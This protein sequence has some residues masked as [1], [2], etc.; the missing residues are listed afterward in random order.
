MAVVG[1]HAPATPPWVAFGS[2]ATGPVGFSEPTLSS[3]GQ[4]AFNATLVGDGI[5]E[6]NDFGIWAGSP[7]NLQLVARAGDPAPG[8]NTT[9]AGKIYD[10]GPDSDP[11]PG[12]PSINSAGRVAFS[13]RLAGADDAKPRNDWGIWAGAPGQVELIARHGQ[14]A[15]G[16][17]GAIFA[18]DTLGRWEE[19]PALKEVCIN[20][21]GQVAFPAF[22]SGTNALDVPYR[23]IYVADPNGQLQLIAATGQQLDLGNGDLRTI[24]WLNFDP[25]SSGQDGLGAN[26]NNAGQLIFAAGFTDESSAIILA[27]VPEPAMLPAFLSAAAL[28][29]R[30]RRMP[31]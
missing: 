26:F 17:P 16:I 7:A 22:I 21:R 8:T 31:S 6:S 5:D 1:D 3:S 9:F 24:K 28:L 13:A 11:T 30:R 4:I 15:P 20:D 29:R 14:P 19:Q 2:P 27:T 18:F 10:S 23:A 25:D 12:P